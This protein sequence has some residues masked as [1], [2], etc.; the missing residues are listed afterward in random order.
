M[1]YATSLAKSAYKGTK[2]VAKYAASYVISTDNKH[3]VIEKKDEKSEDNGYSWLSCIIFFRTPYGKYIVDQACLI[4]GNIPPG[5][6]GF[7]TNFTN[8]TVTSNRLYYNKEI[9]D[10]VSGKS[11]TMVEIDPANVYLHIRVGNSRREKDEIVENISSYDYYVPSQNNKMYKLI[12]EQLI[13]PNV[14]I[15]DLTHDYGSMYP[16][17]TTERIKKIVDPRFLTY[18]HQIYGKDMENMMYNG[19]NPPVL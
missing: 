5:Y 6:H 7:F 14:K 13:Y 2:S 19:I 17:S 16:E 11:Q 12:A 1:N 9:I 18:K 10:P 8:W 15:F 3:N 4:L